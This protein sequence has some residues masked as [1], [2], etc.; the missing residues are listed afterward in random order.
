[1]FGVEFVFCQVIVVITFQFAECSYSLVSGQHCY[2]IEYEL[3]HRHY[4]G[5]K[6]KTCF[7]REKKIGN[8]VPRAE[9]T[10]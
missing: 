6:R 5:K 1:M 4:D 7:G 9:K 2:L 10:K 8:W 3:H